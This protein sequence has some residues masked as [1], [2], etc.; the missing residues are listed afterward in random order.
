[1]H[2]IVEC[3]PNF[4]D[5]RNPEVYNAIAKTIRSVPEVQLLDVSAD[6]IHNR[7]VITF[8]GSPDGVETAA[9]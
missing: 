7:T 4:S 6:P 1:M 2:R 5:G 8:V 3:V 9:F